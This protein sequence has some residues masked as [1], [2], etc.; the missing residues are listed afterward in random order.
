MSATGKA[1]AMHGLRRRALS[2]GVVKSFDYAMQFLLPMLL[3]RCLDEAAF[4]EYRLLG[5]VLG[6][7]ALAPLNMPGGL[8]VFVPRSDAPTKRLY[9]HQTLLFLGV[10][11]L[12]CALLVSPWS[13]LAPETLAP[14]AKFGVLVPAMVALWVTTQM[15]DVLP[16]VDERIPWQAAASLTIG[17][18]RFGLVGTAAWRTHD[19]VL[20]VALLFAISALKMLLLITYIHRYHGFGG[21]WFDRARF[22]DQAR[23]VLPLGVASALFGLRAQ[24][25]QWIAAAL[26]ALTS[27]SAFSIASLVRSVVDIFRQSVVEAF[28]PSMS[29]MQAAGDLRGMLAMNAR[30]NLIVG[31][32]ILPLLAFAF[33]FA[34]QIITVLFTSA[35][36]EGA[37]VMRV[38]LLGL[39]LSVVEVGSIVLMLRQ[40]AFAIAVNCLMLLLSVLASAAF[41]SHVGL[42]GAAAGSVL[43]I[44]VDRAL[45]LRRISRHTGVPVADLQDWRGLALALG[46][47]VVVSACAWTL[48]R[49]E[50]AATHALVQ[51]V[52]GGSVLAAGYLLLFGIKPLRRGLQ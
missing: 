8:Y 7:I 9:V 46:Y 6:T 31:T 50:F 42:A 12:L 38:Y 44:W 52:I 2:L 10:M 23:Q 5:L 43:A 51:L 29:R 21:R 30:G 17:T 48:V 14:L 25:D 11:G 24:A 27:F 4:G 34:E 39:V 49:T 36:L 22:S 37:P 32:L 16:T 41:A 40:G 45:T 3:V 15:L 19:M 1:V 26:F 13:P 47:G 33:C 35:Y 18:L 20:I 28:F